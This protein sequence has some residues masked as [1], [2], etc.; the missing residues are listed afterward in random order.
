[1]RN[2]EKDILHADRHILLMSEC[3]NCGRPIKNKNSTHSLCEPCKLLSER[4]PPIRM[5]PLDTD[6]LELVFA[7]RSNPKIYRHFRKQDAPLNWENHLSWYESRAAGRHDFII[8]Y[9]GRRAGVVSITTDDE[10][11]IYLGDFSAHGNGVAT[12]ALKWLCK[13]FRYRTP[14]IAEIDENNHPSKRLFERCGFQQC[15]CD[16]EWVEYSYDP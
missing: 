6:D 14:L 15:G 4:T 1:M 3:D 8:H 12:A 11:G 16:E 9:D 13:R 10:V 5:T 2:C 7:W